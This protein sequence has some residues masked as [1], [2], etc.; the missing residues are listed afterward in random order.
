MKSGEKVDI[1]KLRSLPC[2]CHEALIWL[3]FSCYR[4][5]GKMAK[6]ELKIG[7]VISGERKNSLLLKKLLNPFLKLL[8]RCIKNLFHMRG[9]DLELEEGLY[10][11]ASALSDIARNDELFH[12]FAPFP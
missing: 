8:Q 4:V 11:I 12:A 1:T 5:A 2:P 7:V 9:K 6:V 3:P 10:K